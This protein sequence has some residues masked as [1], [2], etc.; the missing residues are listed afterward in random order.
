MKSFKQY[1]N[2][3]AVEPAVD[4]EDQSFSATYNASMKDNEK[5]PPFPKAKYDAQQRKWRVGKDG[6]KP[7]HLAKAQ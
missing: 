5:W 7:E 4:F 1:L 6:R 3:E 2:I